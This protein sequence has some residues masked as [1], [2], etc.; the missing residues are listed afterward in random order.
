MGYHI[1]A[2]LRDVDAEAQ[3]GER[4]LVAI[5]E[6]RQEGRLDSGHQES[7]PAG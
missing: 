3:A 6:I 4:N 2:V 5:R 7:L 1:G